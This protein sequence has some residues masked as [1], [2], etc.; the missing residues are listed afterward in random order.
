MSQCLLATVFVQC[1]PIGKVIHPYNGPLLAMSGITACHL[2][3]G[4]VCS[5]KEWG[6]CLMYISFVSQKRTKFKI[7][8]ESKFDTNANLCI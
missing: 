5:I 3:T 8:G 1:L 6:I 2:Q 7:L 4:S